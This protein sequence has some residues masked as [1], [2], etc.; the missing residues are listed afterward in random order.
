MHEAAFAKLSGL[1]RYV[2]GDYEDPHTFAQ[3]R[4]TLAL[5]H[6]E[7]P[8]HYIAIPPSACTIPRTSARRICAH[9]T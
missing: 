7:R 2:D 4:E 8:L 3:V 9:A 5:G 1:L 6:A